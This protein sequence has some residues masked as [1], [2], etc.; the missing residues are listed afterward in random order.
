MASVPSGARFISISLTSLPGWQL[1]VEEEAVWG[2]SPHPSVPHTESYGHW[3]CQGVTHGVLG[4]PWGP[5]DDLCV[6]RLW[7][8]V[9]A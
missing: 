6:A 8:E 5:D 1:C 9:E 2:L 4:G 7:A 3:D